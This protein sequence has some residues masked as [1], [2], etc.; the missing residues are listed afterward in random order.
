MKK[1]L[2]VADQPGWIFDQ[3]CHQ[4]QKRLS[5][6]YDISIAY[7]KQNIPE[8]SNQYD[9]VYVLDPIPMAYPPARKTIMGLRCQ[10]LF[11][12]HPQGAT[13]LYENGFPGRCVSI[14]DKCSIFHVVNQNQMNVFKDIVT[15]KPLVL[16]QHGIDET[17]FVRDV[18]YV[19]PKRDK[20]WVSTSGRSSHNKGFGIVQEA[21]LELGFEYRSANYGPQ[22]IPK[23]QM[24]D[25]YKQ[26]DVHV[27]MSKSEGLNNPLMEASAMGVPVIATKTGAAEELIEDGYNGFLIDRNKESLIAALKKLNDY[28]LRNI[29]SERNSIIVKNKW[30][31]AV[32]IDDFRKMF[33]L[34]FSL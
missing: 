12:E 18:N 1:I 3:H 34:F 11:E 20:L 32:R 29:M 27:C 25:F 24:P 14:K 5:E 19:K 17:L 26:M 4:I 30:T 8:M 2:L 33:K 23:N 22:K 6:E 31:W 10:F 13:G 15:D 9:L 21:C 16:A 28:D 7:R